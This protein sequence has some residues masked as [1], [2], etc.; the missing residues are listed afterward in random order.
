MEDR[1]AQRGLRMVWDVRDAPAA[2]GV[3]RHR[4]SSRC[5]PNVV[6]RAAVAM[7]GLRMAA[8]PGLHNR[9][10]DGLSLLVDD[11]AAGGHARFEPD[12]VLCRQCHAAGQLVL[13]PIRKHGDQR[14]LTGPEPNENVGLRQFHLGGAPRVGY[15]VAVSA[16][17]LLFSPN[18][19]ADVRARQRLALR[20]EDSNPHRAGLRRGIGSLGRFCRLLDRLCLCITCRN[21]GCR[22]RR[23]QRN[24]QRADEP[25]SQQCNAAETQN[26]AAAQRQMKPPLLQCAQAATDR[27]GPGHGDSGRRQ[28]G[29]GVDGHPGQRPTVGGHVAD[30]ARRGRIADQFAGRQMGL[31][32]TPSQR[33]EP[34]HDRNP[35]Q[36]GVPSSV[37]RSHVRQLVGQNAR[38]VLAIRLV[39]HPPGQ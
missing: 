36:A 30:E 8:E 20:I 9:A 25:Y 34:E 38:Q 29:T 15:V 35:L 23:G 7:G 18:A 21:N 33:M 5:Q 2:L 22:R 3:R 11:P 10:G 32:H 28:R 17:T 24:F 6:S 4:L 37:V 31:A 14:L 19:G 26:A 16:E 13:F 12:G 39:A 1:E 27:G